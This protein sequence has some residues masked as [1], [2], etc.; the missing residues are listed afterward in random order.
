[1]PAQR[2]LLKETPQIVDGYVSGNMTLRAL[3]SIYGV[4]NGTIRNILLREGVAL[5]RRGRTR[6]EVTNGTLEQTL[7]SNSL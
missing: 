5:R 3:A 1:M 6:K 2:K 7:Q 4:A